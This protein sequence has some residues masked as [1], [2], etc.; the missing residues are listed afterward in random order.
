MNTCEECGRDYVPLSDM[1]K[2]TEYCSM[3][4]RVK[5]YQR[6]IKNVV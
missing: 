2:K 6:G 1:K 3:L 5:I 4:C